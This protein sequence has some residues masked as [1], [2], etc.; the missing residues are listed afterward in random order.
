MT[1][2]DFST[3]TRASEAFFS[4][5]QHVMLPT[6]L[7]GARP[8]HYAPLSNASVL[9]WVFGYGFTELYHLQKPDQ[10]GYKSQRLATRLRS[11]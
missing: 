8:R 2:E 3:S 11:P 7:F 9:N 6:S 10:A 5:Y 4:C 1:L